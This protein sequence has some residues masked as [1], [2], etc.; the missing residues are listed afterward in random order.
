MKLGRSYQFYFGT[1]QE[2][3]TCSR[4]HCNIKKELYG[5]YLSLKDQP[6]QN[7][8]LKHSASFINKRNDLMPLELCIGWRVFVYLSKNTNFTQRKLMDGE[9][10]G[11]FRFSYFWDSKDNIKYYFFQKN[12]KNYILL[13]RILWTWEALIHSISISEVQDVKSH[14]L[15]VL[16][17]TPNKQKLWSLKL[18]SILTIF[19]KQKMESFRLISRILSPLKLTSL[20]FLST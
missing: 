10:W 2:N 13:C 14:V 11:F 9:L 15:G 4:Y 17:K 1:L 3:Q 6:S 5:F 18:N 7:G 12:T 16:G 20:D 19:K 8:F